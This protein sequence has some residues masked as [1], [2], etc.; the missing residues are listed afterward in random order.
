M[1]TLQLL[2]EQLLLKVAMLLLIWEFSLFLFGFAF[3]IEGKYSFV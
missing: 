3:A 1:Q 2:Q